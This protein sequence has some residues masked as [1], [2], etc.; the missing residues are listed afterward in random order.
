MMATI[1]FRV[2]EDEKNFLEKISAFE[3]VTLSDFI[4]QQAIEAAED[5]M[6]YKTYL[7]L[8]EEHKAE[9]TSISFEEMKQDLGFE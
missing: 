1:T 8:M 6:D 2:T 9:D 5:L 4:R 7:K 3:N